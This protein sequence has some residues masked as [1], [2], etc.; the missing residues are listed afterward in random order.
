MLKRERDTDTDTWFILKATDPYTKGGGGRVNIKKRKK[1]IASTIHN[2]SSYQQ[3]QNL[4]SAYQVVLLCLR[5]F[6]FSE[7]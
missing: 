4:S 3:P 1:N 5:N 7:L 2:I 6:F